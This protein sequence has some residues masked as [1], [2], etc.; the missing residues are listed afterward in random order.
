MEFSFTNKIYLYCVYVANCSRFYQYR[1]RNGL[2]L[3]RDV[4]CNG[5]VECPD[6][7]DEPP[8]CRRELLCFSPMRVFYYL[9]QKSC[10]FSR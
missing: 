7:S 5:T 2:C 6:G 9:R 4:Y 8:N 1:C 10:G 3:R